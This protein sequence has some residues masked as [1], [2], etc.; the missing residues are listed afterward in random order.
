MTDVVAVR[1]K[2]NLT[3]TWVGD[4]KCAQATE[5]LIFFDN[6]QQDGTHHSGDTLSVGH[7]LATDVKVQYADPLT[8]NPYGTAGT[9][10]ARK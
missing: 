9:T 1:N 4:P 8:G 5:Y 7:C 6:V 2:R 10:S 3:I